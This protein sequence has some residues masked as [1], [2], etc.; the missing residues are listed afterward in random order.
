MGKPDV[1]SQL[2]RAATASSPDRQARPASLP[3]MPSQPVSSSAHGSA[4]V[5]RRQYA[6]LCEREDFH[7]PDVLRWIH[8]V[9][10]DEPAESK[11]RRKAW[12]F[13]MVASFLDE[14]GC[15]R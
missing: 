7:D 4:I 9:L 10:P 15:L 11:P 6:K 8:E 1:T 13:A 2:A 5:L 14:V 3:S 12:E